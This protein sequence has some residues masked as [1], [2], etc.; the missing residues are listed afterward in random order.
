MFMDGSFS[1]AGVRHIFIT[2]M[3]RL[4]TVPFGT[5]R[6][7]LIHVN[8]LQVCVLPGTEKPCMLIINPVHRHD[9]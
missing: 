1:G 8:S 7:M 4:L 3:Q 2:N 9:I 6:F 5:N